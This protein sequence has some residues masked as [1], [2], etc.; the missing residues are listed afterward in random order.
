MSC[1][2]LRNVS[3]TFKENSSVVK[4]LDNINIDVEY[5]EFVS[6]TGP[7]G[8]GKSTLLNLIAGLDNPTEGEISIGG[9]NISD[10]SM[11]EQTVFR[12]RYI[13]IVYQN[14]NLM[15]I[16]DIRSNITFPL[17]V[18]GT[19]PDEEYLT[20]I[21]EIL[22]IDRYLDAMP[23]QL[24]G[25]EQQRVA[26]ARALAVKPDIILADEITGNLDTRSGLD[27]LALLKRMNEELGQTVIMV[28]HN[29]EF[30]QIADRIIK[31]EDGKAT[32]I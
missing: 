13:G 25:G 15:D 14:Y 31:I 1:I 2:S 19:A 23:N 32:E 30:A 24:S 3:K 5:G 16:F 21:C 26:I 12:R 7:S 8:S 22:R 18:D 6:I 28:T 4:V 27:V 10:L 29:L 20:N 9:Q 17:E 11:D